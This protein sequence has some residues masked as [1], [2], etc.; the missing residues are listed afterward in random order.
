MALQPI[1]RKS[2]SDDVFDQL[3][4]EILEGRFEAGATLPAER[5]LAEALRVNR[6][7]IREAV[8]RLAQAG[9]IDTRHG[10][11]HHVLDFRRTA[12]LDVLPRLLFGADGDID[13]GTVR[14]VIEMRSALGPDVAR[15]AALRRG[16]EELAAL[17]ALQR[18]HAAAAGDLDRQQAVAIAYWDVVVDAS[19]N[20]A[21]RLAYNSLRQVYERVREAVA[22]VL[23][24]EIRDEATMAAL[25][26]AIAA[27]AGEDA[28]QHALRLCEKG[29]GGLVAAL[30][31]IGGGEGG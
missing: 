9:L 27:G 23:A 30:D 2:L 11:G 3:A 14:A 13:L 4:T 8:R 19:R 20:I 1:A 25:T 17:V 21:Y 29:R 26:A 16:P 15:A 24:D 6:G 28:A 10:S 31:L 5:E 7:A 12:G 22:E 18:D